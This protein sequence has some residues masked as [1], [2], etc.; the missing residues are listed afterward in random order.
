MRRVLIF[1]VLIALCAAVSAFW[2]VSCRRGPDPAAIAGHNVLLIT[3]DTTRADRIGAYGYAK[4]LTPTIDALAQK[5]ALFEQAFAQ[6]PLTLPSHAS[7]MTGRYPR[8]H[9]IRDNARAALGSEHPTLAEMF[10][11]NG[12]R[13]AAFVASFVLDSQFGVDRGFD[14]YSDDMGDQGRGSD[15]LHHQQPANI[16]T[17][18]AL[19]WLA[20]PADSPF[21]CWVHYYDA[22]DPYLPPP[23]FRSPDREMYDGELA[24]MD[25]QIKRLLDWLNSRGQVDRTLVVIVGDHGESFNEHGEKGH[26]NFVYETNLHVPMIFVHPGLVPAASNV[27]SVVEVVDVFPT[28]LDLFGWDSPDGLLSRTLTQALAGDPVDD[29]DAYSESLYVFNAYSWAEQRSLTTRRWKYISS[30]HPELYDRQADPGETR[31]LI[32]EEP[33]VAADL[34]EKLQRRWRDM[35]IG[36]ASDARLDP[37]TQEKLAALGYASGGKH[38]TAQESFL[39]PDLDDPKDNKRVLELYRM[40]R[41]LMEQAQSKEDYEKITPLTRDIAFTCPKALQFQYTHGFCLMKSGRP[42]EAVGVLK[43]ATEIDETHRHSFDLLADALMQIGRY[44]E[45]VKYLEIAKGLNDR[46]PLTRVRLANALDRAGDRS[47]AI[48][49]YREAIKLD[50]GLTKAYGK[51]C[52]VLDDT[53]ELTAIARGFEESIRRRPA[54]EDSAPEPIRQERAEMLYDL[55][56]CYTRIS[57]IGRAASAFEASLVLWPDY[58]KAALNLGIAML[59]RGAL[60]EARA[61]FE[62]ALHIEGYEAEA[63]FHLGAVAAREGSVSDAIR[64]Y[65][66]AVAAK[67]T[68]G[69]PIGELIRYYRDQR[70]FADMVRILRIGVQAQPNEV[71]LLNGLGQVLSTCTDGTVLNGAEALEVLERAAGLTARQEP[72]VL[73]HLGCAYA[74]VG[75]FAEA[76]EAAGAA[77]R[78]GEQRGDAALAQR[79]RQALDLFQKNQPYADPRL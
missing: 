15:P 7:I 13:T 22:H 38:S 55:G 24:F 39:T 53:G 25:T 75:R 66:E 69:P 42:E 49:E 3:L 10:R 18:R 76:A 68:Y 60:P 71:S 14:I 5:G 74:R 52:E 37:D 32:T 11:K 67:P 59:S 17:D 73:F 78:I 57:D 33:A 54:I 72:N 30:T 35:P 9:G 27:T 46:S 12:Y 23:E 20:A 8:E 61:A 79:I 19:E 16:I 58:A 77:L 56:V 51:L 28:I 44:E 63:K 21:F 26:T 65:E 45:A 43:A 50:A 4:A 31:N 6:V 1:G 29:A 48:A 36:K 2:G 62:R 47:Q 41:A 40:A 34:L 64:L 70:R